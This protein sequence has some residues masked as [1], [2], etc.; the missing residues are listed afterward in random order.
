MRKIIFHIAF[1]E[2]HLDVLE[3]QKID[4]LLSSE[5]LFLLVAVQYCYD[6]LRFGKKVVGTISYKQIHNLVSA[7]DVDNLIFEK[8][9]SA[10]ITNQGFKEGLKYTI[11]GKNVSIKPQKSEEPRL[12]ITVRSTLYHYLSIASL[13][14][15]Q[16]IIMERT[17][18][19]KRVCRKK[20]I[21]TISD[22]EFSE[23]FDQPYLS[24]CIQRDIYL[25]YNYEAGRTYNLTI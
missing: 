24:G 17:H 19:C 7:S 5:L 22:T 23:L 3:G 8:H 11:F 13:H 25:I 16:L 9:V 18:H 15:K 21:T 10:R 1:V 14:V 6:A 20:D 2:D 4:G 12:C